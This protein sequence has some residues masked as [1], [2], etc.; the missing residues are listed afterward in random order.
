M[1]V[2]ERLQ[3]AAASTASSREVRA[4][5]SA[6]TAAEGTHA[7]GVHFE[8]TGEDVTECTGGA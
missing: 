4:A 7:G 1:Q 5:S 6:S 3:D 2:V 8:M